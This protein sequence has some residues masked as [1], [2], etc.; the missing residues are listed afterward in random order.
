MT[1]RTI[2]MMLMLA[3][4]LLC[5]GSARASYVIRAIMESTFGPPPT[6]QEI[7]HVINLPECKKEIAEWEQTRPE[8]RKTLSARQADE[9]L[10]QKFKRDVRALPRC[11]KRLV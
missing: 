5:A 8:W 2:V 10:L 3:L 11:I 9:S 6:R 7:E 1:F 4:S